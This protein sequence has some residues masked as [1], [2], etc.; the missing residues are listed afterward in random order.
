L[1][2][3]TRE[4]DTPR[5]DSAEA[6]RAAGRRFAPAAGHE[7]RG[8]I[9]VTG[10]QFRAG[11]SHHMPRASRAPLPIEPVG[12]PEGLAWPPD[13]RRIALV[14][15]PGRAAAEV[16][17]LTLADGALRKLAQF[18][19]PVELDGVTWT[20]DG[21]ALLAGRITYETEVLLL[22]GLPVSRR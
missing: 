2:S 19:A 14:N 8:P 20:G 10:S 6:R 22:R 9:G 21:H 15:L 11:Y 7:A 16:W 5:A 1:A 4:G 13:G 17:V 3:V 12:L 18:E